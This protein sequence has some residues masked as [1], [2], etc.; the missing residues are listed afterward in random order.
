MA[1]PNLRR[2][3]GLAFKENDTTEVSL[4]RGFLESELTLSLAYVATLTGAGTAVKP[5]GSPIRRVQI[6]T[7]GGRVLQ[8]FRPE[9]VMKELQIME[10]T[11]LAA[12]NAPPSA[13]GVAAQAGSIDLVIPFRASH[14]SDPMLTA[15]PTWVYESVILRVE[16]GTVADV[17]VSGGALAGTF[18]TAN[19]YLSANG[20]DDDFAGLGDAYTWGRQLLRLN[21]TFS[22]RPAP[23]AAT[24]EFV[25]ELPRTAAIRAIMLEC[26]DANGLGTNAMLNAIT[27]EV[28]GTLRPIAR[29]WARQIQAGNA[30][31]YGVVM[32]AGVYVIDWADDKDTLDILNATDFTTLNLLLDTNAT[33]GSIRVHLIRQE[34]GLAA[35]A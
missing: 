6:V 13:F 14:A 29:K 12:L 23:G 27:M 35:A 2:I 28:N 8:S 20:V 3:D 33:P 32:P 16:W 1:T 25:I 18:T 11:G 31:L 26:L 4:P 19:V 10:Q 34:P 15:L 5:Y 24:Q 22:E 30:K 21:R 7:D 9:S 17:F